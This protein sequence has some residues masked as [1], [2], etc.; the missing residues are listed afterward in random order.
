MPDADFSRTVWSFLDVETTGLSP[1][2]GDR[3]CEIAILRC[4][5]GEVQEEFQSLVNPE[6]PISPEAQAIHGISPEMVRQSPKFRELAP[7]IRSFIHD[8]IVVCHNAPLDISFIRAEFARI[9]EPLSDLILVDTLK[10]ARKHF[11][12]SS[13][14]LGFLAKSLGVSPQGW[15]RAGNDVEILRRVFDQFLK[16][17]HQRGPL[18]LKQ[19]ITPN[20]F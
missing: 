15:H 10:L 3:V 9:G 13:N 2:S 5:D 11:Q 16:Q 8:S 19:L 1:W 7:K 17:P 18:E 4:R 12:F 20:V 6:R 14:S